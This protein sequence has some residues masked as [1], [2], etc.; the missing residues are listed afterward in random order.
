MNNFEKD[1]GDGISFVMST[2][3]LPFCAFSGLS[4]K[5]QISKLNV[6]IKCIYLNEE[7]P[8]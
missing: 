8:I 3:S 2:P 1:N 6:K 4:F 7:K 5:S